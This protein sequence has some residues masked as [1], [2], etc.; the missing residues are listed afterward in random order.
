ML[1][2]K[3]NLNAAEH[4]L[5]AGLNG[6]AEDYHRMR[7]YGNE[8]YLQKPER[9]FNAELYHQLRK[10]QETEGVNFLIHQEITKNNFSLNAVV[11]HEPQIHKEKPCLEDFN[12]QRVSPDL[13]FHRGQDNLDNQL[14]VAELKMEGASRLSILKDLEKL[15]F[16]KLSSLKFQNAVFIYTGSKNELESKLELG[17]SEKMLQCLIKHNIV[18]ALRELMVREQ[19]WNIYEFDQNQLI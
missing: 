4:T 6:V 3:E 7:H 11:S 13:V 17:L 10:L 16:Y 9:V 5:I 19:N 14:L 8:N 12:N 15:L 2:I 18:I 1:T